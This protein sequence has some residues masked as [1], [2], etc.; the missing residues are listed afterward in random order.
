[1]QLIEKLKTKKTVEIFIAIISIPLI[2]KILYFVN[3]LGIYFGAFLR[4]ISNCIQTREIQSFFFFF[5]YHYIKGESIF[6]DL[7]N[8]IHDK[9]F[10]ILI[11]NNTMN[12]NNYEDI[13]IF[14]DNQILIKSNN[15]LIKIKG[16]NLSITRLEN[17]EVQIEGQIIN[18]ELGD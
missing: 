5:T 14:E 9:T 12:I 18:I 17:K 7:T 4:K 1:M 3:I 6:R 13:L 10:R 16:N 11:L 15:K 2:V 8:I